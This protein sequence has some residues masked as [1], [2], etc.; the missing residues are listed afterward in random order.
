[1]A[2]R[3][4]RNAATVAFRLVFM[5]SSLN[6]GTAKGRCWYTMKDG[7][8]HSQT[9]EMLDSSLPIPATD[10]DLIQNCSRRRVTALYGA[11]NGG[12]KSCRC[13]IAR[14]EE[15]ADGSSGLRTQRLRFRAWRKSGEALLDDE[16][17]EQAWLF[18]PRAT[19]HRVRARQWPTVL[20]LT[21]S[22][23]RARRSEPT[24]CN[25]RWHSRILLL[26]KSHWMVVPRNPTNSRSV[27]GAS[28][29]RLMEII[30]AGRSA[31][32]QQKRLLAKQISRAA[33][34][35]I[36]ARGRQ[37]S[38]GALDDLAGAKSTPR[39]A[40]SAINNC[41]TFNSVRTRPPRASMK[42]VRPPCSTRSSPRARCQAASLRARKI[43]PAAAPAQKAGR[44]RCAGPHSWPR[45]RAN[46]RNCAEGFPTVPGG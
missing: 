3:R 30:G 31:T 6:N 26:S 37:K 43:A 16:R 40:P 27:I 44:K 36:V 10:L 25:G 24:R 32:T 11:F 41:F 45:C 15:S 5:R 38:R 8:I 2:R 7:W 29:H 34:R 20:P 9:Q 18:A 4:R 42:A 46:P 35:R 23:V 39:H 28:N 1:M 17:V 33:L 22:R 12:R 13:P 19:R 21:G 14:Q